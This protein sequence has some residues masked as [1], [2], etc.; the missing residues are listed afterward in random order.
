MHGYDSSLTVTV[1]S[2]GQ[3]SSAVAAW[4]PVTFG[5]TLT[6]HPN[7]VGGSWQPLQIPS[8]VLSGDSC[9]EGLGF[10]ESSSTRII[11]L[12]NPNL[13]LHML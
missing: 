8:G 11:L 10:R 7:G 5:N 12:Y 1:A 9:S 4:T 6:L 2:V 13:Y 3:V